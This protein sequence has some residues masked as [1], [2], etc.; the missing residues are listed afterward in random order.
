MAVRPTA[1]LT[2][3]AEIQPAIRAG[4]I[5]RRIICRG[6]TVGIPAGIPIGVGLD[7]SAVLL[8]GQQIPCCVVGICRAGNAAFTRPTTVRRYR[9]KTFALINR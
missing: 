9:M 2:M 3:E 6:A 5:T 1:F 8:L 7:R 4:R